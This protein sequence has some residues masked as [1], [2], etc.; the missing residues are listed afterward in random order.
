MLLRLLSI[1]IFIIS[2]FDWQ[3]NV[4]AQG[5]FILPDE[6]ASDQVVDDRLERSECVDETEFWH[7]DDAAVLLVHAV[8]ARNVVQVTEVDAEVVPPQIEEEVCG[9]LEVDGVNEGEGEDGN[10]DVDDGGRP[11]RVSRNQLLGVV[12]AE[13]EVVAVDLVRPKRLLF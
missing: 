8:Q 13:F 5:R 3:R 7:P 10:V 9:E 1:R 2:T 12:A 6:E 4:L 11:S